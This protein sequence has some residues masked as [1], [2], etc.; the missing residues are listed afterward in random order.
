VICKSCG[1]ALARNVV[2]EQLNKGKKISFCH[3]CGKK[4]T[5]PSPEPLTRLLPK[6]EIEINNQQEI[7][8][9]RTAFEVAL[10]RVKGLL[11]DRKTKKK[12]TC[13]ISYAWGVSENERWVLQL[14]KD[15]RNADIDVLLDRWDSPPGSNLDLYIDRIL[16]SDFVIPVGTPEL[17]K[18]YD[19]RK[20]DPVVVAELKLINLRVRQPKEYGDTILPVLLTGNAK[21]SFT[22][23]LQPLVSVDFR[24]ADYYFRKLFDMI[25]RMYNLPFDN[26]LLEE[27]QDSM[28]PQEKP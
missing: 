27:L 2:F 7:A 14:A 9:Y 11:R 24:E 8:D 10:V 17:R 12:A 18:K 4:V 13:F 19:S 15:L 23:Q 1:T 6:E 16:S 21:T 28:T 20:A 22:P 5:L 25:W 26:P 3:E